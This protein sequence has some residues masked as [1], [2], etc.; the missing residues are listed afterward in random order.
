MTTNTFKDSIAKLQTALEIRDDTDRLRP[1]DFAL[2][3]IAR[4][5]CGIYS[6]YLEAGEYIFTL[7]PDERIIFALLCLAAEDI[8]Y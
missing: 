5:S 4:Y 3:G 1:S 2:S 8:Y 7:T 6:K